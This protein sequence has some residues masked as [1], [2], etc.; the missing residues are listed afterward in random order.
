MTA[1]LSLLDARNS[2]R[3]K[4][5]RQACAFAGTAAAR[6]SEVN[7]GRYVYYHCTGYKGKCPEPYTR[8]DQSS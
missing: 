2:L 5:Q 4:R 1:S 7:N 3:P 6:V 8:E